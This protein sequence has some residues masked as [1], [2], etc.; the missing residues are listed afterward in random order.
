MSLLQASGLAFRHDSQ[1]DWLFRNVSFNIDPGDRV[2]LV[3][4]NGSGKTSLLRILAGEIQAIDG[5]LVRRSGLRLAYVRQEV[6]APA[7]ELLEDFILDADS[8]LGS[9]RREWRALEARLEDEAAALCYADLLTVYEAAGGYLFEARAASVLEGLGFDAPERTLEMGQLSSGQRSRAELARLLLSP[10]DLLLIDEPTNHLD[11]EAREWL[12]GYLAGIESACLLISH[13]RVFLNRVAS[14]TFELRR[15]AL[16]AFGGSYELYREQRALAERQAWERYEAQQRREAA[17]RRAAEQRDQTARKVARAPVGVRHGHDFYQAKAARL[18]RTARILRERSLHEPR[19]VKPYVETVIPALDFADV[20]RCGGT[21]LRID[22]LAKSFDGKPLF[23][24]LSLSV[25]RGE[26]YALVGPNGS[27]KTTLLRIVRGLDRPDRGSVELG[28][29]VRVGYFSQE[30]EHMDPALSP[31]A[32]CLGVNSNEEWVRTL[33]ACLKIRADQV[34]QPI[35]SMSGGER[36]KV[37]LAA[38][39]VGEANLLLL[40]EPTNH[41]DI[42]AREALEATLAQYPGAILFVSHDRHFVEELGDA[43]I[44]LSEYADART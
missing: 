8:A 39:L 33:L 31:L 22:G 20:H 17:A 14:R 42:E 25:G 24:G 34:R 11:V 13:D 15:G 26:R 41:L 36:A 38:L 6:S 21:V 9:L 10:A 19:A 4:P 28:A 12:E 23:D 5:A 43:V 3:G 40:D 1:T 27:G 18:Q 16:T 2:A 37:A 7:G 35:G 44:D 30:G 32:F 29:G